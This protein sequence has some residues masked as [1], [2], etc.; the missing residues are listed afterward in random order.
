MGRII[1]SLA[2]ADPLALLKNMQRL[3]S[4]YY[5]LDI[6][7]GNFVPNI[8]FGM[9]TVKAVA[10]NTT[11]KL[12]AH[13]MVTN[14]QDYIGPLAQAGLWAVSFHYEAAMYP[15]DLLGK[16]R[17]AGMQAGLALNFKTPAQALAPFAQALD[18]VLIMTAEPDDMGQCFFEPILDKIRSARELLPPT[19]SIWVDG[20]IGRSEI[21][22]VRA[23][24]ADTIILGRAIWGSAEPQTAYRACSALLNE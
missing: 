14:P 4:V 21:V 15:L 22:P 24:G 6:E 13:L 3:D 11:A 9:K 8:T 16:I 1:P 7:D 5:H 17:H 18:Y 20:G 12:D 10:Q 2:S 23:A 19:I